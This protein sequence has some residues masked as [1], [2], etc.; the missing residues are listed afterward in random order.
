MVAQQRPWGLI[1]AAVVVAVF[2]AAVIGYA[3]TQANRAE[4][5]RITSADQIQGVQT[6][7]YAVGQQHVTTPVDYEQSPPV[8]GPHDPNWADC[9]GTVYDVDIG[10]EN[11][12]HALEH[13][14]VWIAYDPA[15]LSPDEVGVLSDLVDGH[16][17]LL[18]SPYAGL[19]SP[20][21]LQSWNHQL[22]VDSVRDPR[23]EQ[24]I[25]F[26]TFN[27]DTTPEPG[28]SCENPAF[29][30]DPPTAEVPSPSS[31]GS[32]ASATTSP[33]TA[34]ASTSGSATP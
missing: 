31:A 15:A 29:V 19:D 30:A 34:G 27:P 20:I 18:L 25:D 17:G 11:A 3:V 21:S 16:A 32:N 5:N 4:A 10:H 7:D 6:F 13:G 28:A 24:Y 33:S 1:A 26:F 9:T 23:I 22:T 12:V 14:G 2:A 8:G